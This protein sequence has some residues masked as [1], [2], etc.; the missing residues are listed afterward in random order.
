MVVNDFDIRRAACSAR[1]HEADA[2]LCLD[3]YA[4]LTGA[5]ALQRFKAIASQRAQLVDTG[6]SIENFQAAISL[7]SKPLEFT[8]EM[9]ISKCSSPHVPIAQDHYIFSNTI[10]VLR[11]A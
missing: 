10:Y 8:D 7:P 9:S 3:P 5:I 1:P 11:Q 4:E 2:P 6:G